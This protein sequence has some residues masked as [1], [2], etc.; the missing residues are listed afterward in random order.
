M[1]KERVAKRPKAKLKD[2]LWAIQ[3]QGPGEEVRTYAA[4][5]R[6]EAYEFAAHSQRFFDQQAPADSGFEPF[7]AMVVAWPG[8]KDEFDESVKSAWPE[9]MD[10]FQKSMH[11]VRR[12]QMPRLE[13]SEEGR[14]RLEAAYA[15]HAMTGVSIEMWGIREQM[16]NWDICFSLGFTSYAM[17]IKHTEKHKDQHLDHIREILL[18]LYFLSPEFPRLFVAPSIIKLV[19][20]L[21]NLGEA[22]TEAEQ[23][24]CIAL[25]APILGRDRGSG[26]R[27]IRDEQSSGNPVSLSIRRLTTKVFSMV[28]DMDPA[29]VRTYF[30][31]IA[32]TTA[33][34]RGVDT[35][36]I[37]D[38][39][40]ERGVKVD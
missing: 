7:Q 38:L 21:F 32:L 17:L 13:L 31:K 35:S 40:A 26:Y 16:I 14:A 1:I 33:H 11:V 34:A 27:W 28:L 8:S 15:P 19:D 6:V 5:S 24:R 25:M 36:I 30:W 37:E 29:A 20:F 10:T 39:L 22:P 3:L 4:P 18:R 9:F 23:K 12:A 2:Q